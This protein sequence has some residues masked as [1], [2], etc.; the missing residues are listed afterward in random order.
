MTTP[1]TTAPHQRTLKRIVILG[2]GFGGIYTTLHLQKIF[3]HHDAVEIVLINNDNYFLMSPLLFEAG[4]GVLEPRHAVTPIRP[5]LHKARFIEADVERIDVDKRL[6]FARHTP[7]DKPYEIPYDHLVLALGG[8]TNRSLIP[9]SEF[10]LGFKNLRD[11]IYLRNHI[12]DLFEQ[13]DASDDPEEIRRLLNFVIIGGGLV[14]VELI[15]ELTE[16]VDN[17]LRSYPRISREHIHFALLDASPRILSEMDQEL[18]DYAAETLWRRGVEILT[19]V[20]VQK[21]EPFA[22]PASALRVYLPA[23][24]RGQARILEAETV[25]LCAGVMPNPLIASMPAESLKGKIVVEPT[26]RVTSL[27]NVWALGDCA[28][29]PDKNGKPYPPL[30]QHAL[31]QAKVVA[32]NIARVVLNDGAHLQ[33]FVYESKGTLASLGHYDGVGKVLGI[34]IRGFAAWWVWRTYYVMQMPRWERRLRV[35]LDW[36]IALLFRN[37]VV[38]LD[39]FG[40]AHPSHRRR[41]TGLG[42]GS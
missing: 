33:P 14:G 35:I 28:F 40:Q 42:F 27:G 6:V 3:R 26:M 7:D 17:L 30:A 16:F 20:R 12:I 41:G 4:S 21:I 29:I 13:A 32:H 8:K 2:G 18:A 19:N 9:G 38:K 22:D 36:T 25:L 31:R 15:G 5:L 39:L 34:K 10:A 23:D 37:D 24:A 11:A 1:P